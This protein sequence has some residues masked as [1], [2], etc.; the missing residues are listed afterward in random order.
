MQIRIAKKEDSSDIFSVINSSLKDGFT[1][2]AVIEAIDSDNALVYVAE[3][4][5]GIEGFVISYF[6]A[7]EAEL[8][9]IAVDFRARKNGVATGLI[10]ELKK[11]LLEK[12]IKTLFL[13]VRAGN[14]AAR[15]CY[16][17][18]GM[19]PC[20]KRPGFYKEPEEDAII[21]RMDIADA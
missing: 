2:N 5:S 14:E 15:K 9:Q 8:L 13:E 11:G 4:S 3:E 7:D 18:F 20:G 19:V 21:Y 16:E 1:E 12:Q 17:K 10:L 6:A